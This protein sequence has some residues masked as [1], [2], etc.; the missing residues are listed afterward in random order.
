MY[1]WHLVLSCHL[2]L[3]G[4]RRISL[5]QKSV[6]ELLNGPNE[7]SLTQR[8][9]GHSMSIMSEPESMSLRGNIKNWGKETPLPQTLEA[10]NSKL[11]CRA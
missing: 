2:S 6:T 4:Q 8:P 10:R 11:I 7:I 5:F 3:A 9:V 1:G